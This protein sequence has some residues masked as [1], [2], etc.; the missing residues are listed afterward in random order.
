MLPGNL[1]FSEPNPN[2]ESLKAGIL[3]VWAPLNS[4]ICLTAPGQSSL[5]N[6][7]PYNVHF[8]SKLLSVIF[9]LS[10]QSFT[11]PPIHELIGQ[12]SCT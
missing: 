5:Y 9:A 6:Y 10:I 7:T 4:G 8:N 2:S 12:S 11:H 3:K 1:H